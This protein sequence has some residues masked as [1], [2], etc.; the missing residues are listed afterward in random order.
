MIAQVTQQPAQTPEE[1]YE[2][3]HKKTWMRRTAGFLGGATLFAGVGAL[4]GL[5]ASVMPPLLSALE[6][7]GAAAGVGMPGLLTVA[8]NVALFGG[9]A[10]WLGLTIGADVGANAGSAAASIEENE[11]LARA[12]GGKGI[13]QSTEP[14]KPVK[15]FNWKVGLFTGLLLATFGALIALNPIT[16]STVALMGFQAGSTAASVASAAVLGGL[17]LSIGANFA[18]LSHKL[19]A[20]YA[21]ILKGKAFDKG[22]A[23][24]AVPE[25]SAEPALEYDTPTRSGKSFTSEE[26][27]DKLTRIITKT[28]ERSE[29]IAG[30]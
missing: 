30:R 14:K 2:N 9:A 6:V 24:A 19:S 22:E 26:R 17:G 16:A 11:K 29:L 7:P 4:G 20:G 13:V 1:L 8:S 10:A 3:I 5:L 21:K 15:L 28:E 25:K 18:H 27:T 23:P 12:N